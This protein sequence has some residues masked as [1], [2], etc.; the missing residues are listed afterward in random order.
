MVV[1]RGGALVAS[2]AEGGSWSE[3]WPLKF[4]LYRESRASSC[5]CL[6][7][8]K[9]AVSSILEPTQQQ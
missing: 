2:D 7:V 8:L 4:F 9:M 1:S 5:I 6:L 3:I